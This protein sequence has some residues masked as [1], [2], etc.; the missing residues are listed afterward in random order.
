MMAATAE[1]AGGRQGDGE[2]LRGSPKNASG[3]AT[4]GRIM[5]RDRQSLLCQNQRS[6][7]RS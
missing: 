6:A 7:C 1:T 3:Q 2:G 4:S 5:A